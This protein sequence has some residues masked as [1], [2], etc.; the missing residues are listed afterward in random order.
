VTISSCDHVTMSLET[1][2]QWANE[3]MG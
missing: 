1:I 2:N 3:Q